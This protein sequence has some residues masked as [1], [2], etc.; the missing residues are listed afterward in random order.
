MKY[1]QIVLNIPLNQ[2][3]TYSI[4]EEQISECKTELQVGLRAEI[5]FGNRK[6]TGFI[7]K[8][9]IRFPITFLFQKKKYEQLPELLIQNQFLRRNYTNLQNGFQNIIS[10]Q[11]EKLFF[12]LFHQ[13]EE[14]QVPRAFLLITKSVIKPALHFLQ[15]RQKL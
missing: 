9:W 8:F 12:P 10:V 7:T 2:A 13:G 3:F 14:K 5:R 1:L 4:T 11:L 15:N 6:A